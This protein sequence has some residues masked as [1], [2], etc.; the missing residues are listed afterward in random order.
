M[1]K[2]K[3]KKT[4]NQ[5]FLLEPLIALTETLTLAQ[6]DAVSNLHKFDIPR[7]LFLSSKLGLPEAIV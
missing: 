7:Q 5:A 3:G 6:P 4:E 1:R 2:D